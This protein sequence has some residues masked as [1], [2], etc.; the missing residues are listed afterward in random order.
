MGAHRKSRK[1]V[2]T[3]FIYLFILLVVNFFFNSRWK[4]G[5]LNLPGFKYDVQLSIEGV[6]GSGQKG[7][8]VRFKNQISSI[9]KSFFFLILLY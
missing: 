5:Q 1:Q 4:Y 3:Y 6:V 2:N 9:M 7:H 8:I